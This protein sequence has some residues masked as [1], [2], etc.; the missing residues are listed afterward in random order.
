MMERP[1]HPTAAATV[2][3][4][5]TNA[6]GN[7]QVIKGG[8]SPGPIQVRIR[9]AGASDVFVKAGGDNTAAAAVANDVPIAANSVEVLTFTVPSSTNTG[10]WIAGIT[11]S[12]TATLYITPGVGI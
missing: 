11:A 9:N 1:F 3:L 8:G 12:G 5:A 10:L 4:A 6:S 2:S 7:V